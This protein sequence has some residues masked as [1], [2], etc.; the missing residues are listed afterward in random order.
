MNNSVKHD[1]LK[2]KI[3]SCGRMNFFGLPVAFIVLGIINL[4]FIFITEIREKQ[5]VFIIGF[6]GCL[7]IGVL[8]YLLQLYR[9]RYKSFKLNR[10]LKDFKDDLR[11]IL[12][13]NDWEIDYDNNKYMQATYRGSVI[14]QNVVC[15]ILL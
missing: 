15:G 5:I 13:S 8:M 9:L 7:T 6:I 4:Y 1:R 10:D 14:N 2:F 11:D 12:I 3:G